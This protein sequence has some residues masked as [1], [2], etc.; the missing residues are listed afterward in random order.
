M[1]FTNYYQ[2]FI[3]KYAHIP[4]PIN[5]L[6]SG[7]SANKK[8]APVE[9]TEE[10]QSAYEHLKRLCSQTP[11]L[12]YANYHK[13]F[14]L[15]TDASEN[16][17]GAILYQKQDDDT[18]HVIV[19]AS[20]TLSKSE[21]NYDT[22]RL[23]FLALKWSITERFHEYLYG[24]HFD[25]YTDNNPLTYILTTAKLDATGQRWVASLDNY[26]FKIFYKSGKLNV[27][28]DA[29]SCILWGNTQVDHMEPLI[30]KT[31]LQ[32]KLESETSLPNEYPPVDLLLKS[33]IVDS[34]L[35]LTRNDWIKEQMD[36]MDIGKVTQ[37]LET[38]KLNK[39]VV[40]EMDSSGMRVLLKYRKNLFLNNGL[41]YQKVT[42]KNI[43]E[44][45]AQFVLPKRFI[46]KVILTCHNDNGHVGM[47]RTL[48][49]L[50]GRFF[51]PK[52]AEDVC[53]HIHTCARCLRFKQP[54]EKAEM[55]L[56]LVSYPVELIHL[57]FLTLG[58]KAGDTKL[59]ISWL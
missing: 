40:Q 36:D 26:N 41:L 42:L 45:V 58:G 20:R 59:S 57:Y 23:E 56:I 49:L 13:P 14:K 44:L 9:W 35:K 32:S 10:C 16:G 2:K 6:V 4:R 53:I 51:W 31:M 7:E 39:Y 55:Q 15:H 47:E 19:Y 25:V 29:L 52:M 38:N 48:G 1:G 5:R 22:H 12:A 37:L 28:A 27:E 21:K 24:G 50:Q 8:K 43:L 46:H 11:V 30:V 18:E 34:T 54:Q 33:M 17:L 3:P